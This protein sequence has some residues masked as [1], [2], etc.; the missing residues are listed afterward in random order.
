M[1]AVIKLEKRP[2]SLQLVPALTSMSAF[3]PKTVLTLLKNRLPAIEQKKFEA[4]WN[5]NV[6]NRYY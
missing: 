1:P 2:V 4:D 3:D 5:Q 6:S